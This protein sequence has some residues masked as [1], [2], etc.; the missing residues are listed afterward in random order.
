[1]RLKGLVLCLSV[2]PLTLGVSQRAQAVMIDFDSQGFSGPSM[3]MQ[4]SASTI[5]VSTSIG[6]VAFSGGA[7]LTNATNAPADES[8][9]YYTS[10]FLS[11]GRNP[12]TITFPMAINNFFLDVYNGESSNETFT[13]SDNAGNSK[14]VTLMPNL[15]GGMSLVSFAAAG[16][17]VTIS[18]AGGGPF[19][20]AIDNIG[21]DEPTPGEMGSGGGGEMGG[22]GAIPE[23]ASVA[24]LGAALVGL[25]A[26]LRRR[27]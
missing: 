3:A 10:D 5:S 25:G 1:M 27:A 19:D 6:N 22:G 11:G 8:S 4:T 7:I 17:S 2:I 13:V 12:L 23:P 15:M 18:Q 16:T 24:L 26:S 9:I 21:F 20:F 14:T